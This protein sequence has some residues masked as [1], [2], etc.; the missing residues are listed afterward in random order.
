MKLESYSDWLSR[1]GLAVA[2]AGALWTSNPAARCETCLETRLMLAHLPLDVVGMLY[3]SILFIFAWSARMEP[4]VRCGSLAAAGAHLVLVTF[5]I[6]KRMY[7][8]SCLLTAFGAFFAA[9]ACL[10]RP[11]FTL[12][13]HF[14]PLPTAGLLA[15]FTVTVAQ[16]AALTEWREKA[17][18]LLA[19]ELRHGQTN[20]VVRVVYYQRPGCRHCEEFTVLRLPYLALTFSNGVA[21][22]SRLAPT[23]LP[24][25][26]VFVIGRTNTTFYGVPSWPALSNAVERAR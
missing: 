17:G 4:V 11:D 6:K 23:N 5:L 20:S 2:L 15:V 3:Y 26:T 10:A 13:R 14:W 22:E 25:P 16:H 9:G 7:C 12:R 21:S 24:T 1:A 8:P 18:P 19:Q